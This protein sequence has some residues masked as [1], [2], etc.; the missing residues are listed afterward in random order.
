MHVYLFSA[1][2]AKKTKPKSQIKPAFNL[3][4]EVNR[5]I[6]AEKGC[7]FSKKI[8]FAGQFEKQFYTMVKDNNQR[9]DGLA[10]VEQALTKTEQFFEKNLNYV[11]YAV[12]GIIVVV[13]GILGFQKYIVGAKAKEAQNQ[14]FAAQ[15]YFEKDSFNLAIN[16]D[17]N[18]LG[19]LDIIDNYGSTKSGKLARYYVGVSYLHLG[20][21]ENAIKYLDKFKTD[22]LLLAPLAESA[23]GDAFVELGKYPKAI[24]AYKN[25][26]GYKENDFSTPLVLLKLGLAYEAN[27]QKSDALEQY[28]KIMDQFTASAEY[29][30]A[31]KFHARLSQL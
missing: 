15:N 26:L 31:E 14:I 28:K 5:K 7:N 1:K 27:G 13:L 20:E 16:G 22:D 8:I 17:G 3:F 9:H 23:T 29:A 10:E 30:T 18:S 4:V 19:F 12:I 25:A 11:L 6:V 21:Y 2:L 24:S